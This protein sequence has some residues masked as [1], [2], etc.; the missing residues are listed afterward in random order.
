M[1]LRKKFAQ[2]PKPVIATF[3]E[4]LK[5]YSATVVSSQL[6]KWLYSLGSCVRPKFPSDGLAAKLGPGAEDLG[7]IEKLRRIALYSLV[8]LPFRCIFSNS[9][10]AHAILVSI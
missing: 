9:S 4:V 8:N 6:A 1:R 10:K 3:T 2:K 5:N 7:W